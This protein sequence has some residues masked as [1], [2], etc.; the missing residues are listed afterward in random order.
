MPEPADFLPDDGS[1]LL[2][3]EPR[4]P[5]ELGER[6]VPFA[7]AY[8]TAWNGLIYERYDSPDDPVP[9]GV[10]AGETRLPLLNDLGLPLVPVG[11]LVFDGSLFLLAQTSFDE[12]SGITS[13]FGCVWR[14]AWPEQAVS[15]DRWRYFHVRYR[16]ATY[17]DEAEPLVV[18]TTVDWIWDGTAGAASPQTDWPGGVLQ[19]TPPPELGVG[20]INRYVYL[21]L[22]WPPRPPRQCPVLHADVLT[23]LLPGRIP[24]GRGL[25][26][27]YLTRR[28]GS[29]WLEE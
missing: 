27:D 13:R 10:L 8:V 6:Q 22:L 9:S 29:G 4:R 2:I 5:A 11:E 21:E 28:Q 24:G 23:S 16:L 15:G 18:G 3:E 14:F 17:T 25:R 7:G 12:Y 26:A 20:E 19:H 1:V